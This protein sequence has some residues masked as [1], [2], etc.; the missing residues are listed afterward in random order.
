MNIKIRLLIFLLMI[1]G[2][3]AIDHCNAD[4]IAR[5][6]AEKLEAITCKAEK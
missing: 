6:K 5:H 2:S 3:I 1:A 4:N